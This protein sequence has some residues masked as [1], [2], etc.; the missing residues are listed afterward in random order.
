MSRS[1]IIL[2]GRL[3]KAPPI[4]SVEDV[5]FK[6]W[7]RHK[8]IL[9][10]TALSYESKKKGHIDLLVSHIVDVYP[11]PAS[12][13]REYLFGVTLSSSPRV[14]Y[15][16]AD[17]D[18][19]RTM[20]MEKIR[21]VS[22]QCASLKPNDAYRQIFKD[23]SLKLSVRIP[24][25][26]LQTRRKE[27]AELVFLPCAVLIFKGDDQTPTEVFRINHIRSFG[28]SNTTIKFNLGKSHPEGH[29][30]RAFTLEKE[31]NLE[32]TFEEVSQ[33]FQSSAQEYH[34]EECVRSRFPSFTTANQQQSMYSSIDHTQGNTPNTPTKKLSTPQP[35]PHGISHFA[36]LYGDKSGVLE[37]LEG[38]SKV[39][40]A[41][42]L[43]DSVVVVAPFFTAVSR[44]QASFTEAFPDQKSELGQFMGHYSRSLLQNGATTAEAIYSSIDTN[45]RSYAALDLTGNA[46]SLQSNQSSLP[47][48]AD[49]NTIQGTNSNNTTTSCSS[50]NNNNSNN[51]DSVVNES[52]S[53][54]K[55]AYAHINF[56][57]TSALCDVTQSTWAHKM[58]N[59][60][61]DES[62]VE[63][64]SDLHR[65]RDSRSDS[66]ASSCD[67]EG[68][69]NTN[70]GNA[71]STRVRKKTTAEED[72]V[73]QPSV[74]LDDD[75]NDLLAMTDFTP[76]GQ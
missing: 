64:D 26:E 55:S 30:E 41:D 49:A 57:A 10:N 69:K 67:D 13:G 7:K 22:P 58:G 29:G 45:R 59:P 27:E 53:S 42:M 35:S 18:F 24:I 31:V 33:L 23:G 32:P 65:D 54:K 71:K 48:Q 68:A 25:R 9:T 3:L 1:G 20:W 19:S 51:K 63:S 74:S 38:K 76:Q 46:I 2:E 12:K 73:L 39:S 16:E 47:Q 11:V 8:F 72:G 50:K 37:F 66:N 44:L 36:R 14:Y 21:S 70:N 56:E 4:D 28:Q 40:V 17:S 34:A 75:I 5:T 61:L 52:G 60:N 15:F 62:D 6:R 43:D